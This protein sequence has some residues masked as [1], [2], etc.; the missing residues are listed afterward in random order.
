M[1]AVFVVDFTIALKC[2]ATIRVVSYSLYSAALTVQSSSYCCNDVTV[3]GVD[4]RDKVYT[5]EN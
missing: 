4:F 1:Q 2:T 5:V 3:H